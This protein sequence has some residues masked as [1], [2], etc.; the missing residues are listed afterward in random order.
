MDIQAL[1]KLKQRCQLQHLVKLVTEAVL[2]VAKRELEGASASMGGGGRGEGEGGR[3][4][5]GREGK[6]YE[7]KIKYH[8]L[9]VKL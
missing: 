6:V 1:G 4:G 8:N 9:N 7:I 2:Q 3:E 5:R